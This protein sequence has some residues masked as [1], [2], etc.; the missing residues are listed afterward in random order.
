VT[1]AK[2]E[3]NNRFGDSPAI[4]REIRKMNSEL[5][6][7]VHRSPKGIGRNHTNKGKRRNAERLRKLIHSS[8]HSPIPED[9]EFTEDFIL[10]SALSVFSG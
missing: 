3:V 1:R 5:T 8:T 7:P 6:T 10:F 2:Q 9:T 4:A